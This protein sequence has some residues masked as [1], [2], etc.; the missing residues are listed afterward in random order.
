MKKGLITFFIIGILIISGLIVYLQMTKRVE[1]TPL[2]MPQKIILEESYTQCKPI[3]VADIYEDKILFFAPLKKDEME[4]GIYIYNLTSGETTQ[5][6][7]GDADEPI[8]GGIYGNIAVWVYTEWAWDAISTEGDGYAYPSTIDVYGYNLKTKEVFPVCTDPGKQL[9]PR[10]YGDVVVWND[11]QLAEDGFSLKTPSIY[12]YN[13]KTKEKIL[14]HTESGLYPE[15]YD[16]IVVW[17]DIRG[18]D[19]DIYA[20]DMKTK[21]EFPVCIRSGNQTNPIIWKD[22]IIYAEDYSKLCYY[23]LTTKKEEIIPG[24][25]SDIYED[26]TV[27]VETKENPDGTITSFI[28]LYNLTTKQRKIIYEKGGTEPENWQ[29]FS[30]CAKPQIYGNTVIW[31]EWEEDTW[32]G[33]PQGDIFYMKIDD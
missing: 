25:P 16:N 26:R 21:E 24:Y 4:T 22:K 19:L 5:I 32:F 11:F 13:L 15:I 3:D 7:T 28:V 2:Y 10:I 27:W 6:E 20:Y 33:L 18:K 14:I 17:K 1:K 29:E 8:P 9:Y 23:N 30:F 31:M 12:A